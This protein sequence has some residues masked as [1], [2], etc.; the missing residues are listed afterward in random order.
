MIWRR[1]L[2]C[3]V[4]RH[5]WG[6]WRSVAVSAGGKLAALAYY[7]RQCLACGHFETTIKKRGKPWK[8]PNSAK[9][10]PL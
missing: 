3:L 6:R 4:G 10:Y 5:Y 8:T 7:K 1:L 2:L 9:S